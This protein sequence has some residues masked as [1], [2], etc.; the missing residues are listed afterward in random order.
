[1]SKQIDSSLVGLQD[2]SLPILCLISQ[3]LVADEE[4]TVEAVCG[5]DDEKDDEVG[6][7]GSDDDD[8][9]TDDDGGSGVGDGVTHCI[10][11]ASAGSLSN[12]SATAKS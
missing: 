4:S 12:L 6:G 2:V 9:D 7:G 5:C 3:L 8:I 1:M 10:G 11:S